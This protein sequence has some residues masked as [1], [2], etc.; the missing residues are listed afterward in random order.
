MKKGPVVF[1]PS[2]RPGISSP[3]TKFFNSDSLVVLE[4]Q[5]IFLRWSEALRVFRLAWNEW[6]PLIRKQYNEWPLKPL[7][8][9]WWLPLLSRNH[10]TLPLGN[11]HLLPLSKHNVP[12]ALL[13]VPVLHGRDDRLVA[14]LMVLVLLLDGNNRPVPLLE[15]F[16]LLHANEGTVH[17][18][19]RLN[20]AVPLPVTLVLLFHGRPLEMLLFLVIPKDA[21]TRDASQTS[22]MVTEES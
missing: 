18:H 11:W 4:T 16:V 22:T 5:A 3:S 1:V 2:H 17:L 10:G 6:I 19:R 21:A 13:R 14:L 9:N 12:V 7:K 20:R 8:C 15:V